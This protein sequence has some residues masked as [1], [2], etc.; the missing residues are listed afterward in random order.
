VAG[1]ATTGTSAADVAAF[2][3]LREVFPLE[4]ARQ[5]R[6]REALERAYARLAASPMALLT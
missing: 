2:L 3:E 5:A 6:F 1:E 4:L